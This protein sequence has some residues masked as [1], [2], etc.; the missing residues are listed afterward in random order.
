MDLLSMVLT[1]RP[2]AAPDP[3]ALLPEWWGRAAHALLLRVIAQSNPALAAAFHET[4]GSP[5]EREGADEAVD[6]IVRPFTASTLM[7]LFPHC[8]LDT[9]GVYR[10]RFSALQPEVAEILQQAAQDGPLAPGA[11]VELDHLLFQVE[12]A[13]AS[14]S[15]DFKTA[16]QNWTGSAT[17]AELS[18]SLLRAPAPPPRR[19]SFLFTSPVT[20]KSGG[21]HM[22]FPLPGL[23]FGSLLERWNAF[24]PVTF[25]PETRR[26]AEE[27]LAISFYK[28][29]SR[30]APVKRGGMRVGGVGEITFTTVNYDRYWMSVLG[31]LAQF[32]LYSGVGAGTTTGLGQCRV[33][34]EASLPPCKT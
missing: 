5:V 23:V 27:C 7:G 17:Y 19:I 10:L 21:K 25:P 9:A 26:Y 28:L 15:E 3:N 8:Q 20:F 1:L 16:V 29:S 24:A 32:A 6:H 14:P 34:G 12:G 33:A 13:P 22:P 11:M 2:L 18:A 30:A 4:S 31:V